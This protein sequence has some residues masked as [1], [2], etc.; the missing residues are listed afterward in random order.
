MF[1]QQVCVTAIMSVSNNVNHLK[2]FVQFELF[3]YDGKDDSTF[4]YGQQW[5]VGKTNIWYE[6]SVSHIKSLL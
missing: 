5:I 3:W 6:W 1:Q 2:N 4:H